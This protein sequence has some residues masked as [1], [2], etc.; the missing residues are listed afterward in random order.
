[1]RFKKGDICFYFETDKI[2]K[3]TVESIEDWHSE[4][5]YTMK[6]KQY[7]FSEEEVLSKKEMK[8]KLKT[9]YEKKLKELED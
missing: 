8:L 3:L 6:E 1:M 9:E 5:V 4:Q 7:V 2:I